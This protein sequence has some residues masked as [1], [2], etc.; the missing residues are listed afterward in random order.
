VEGEL[1]SP[2]TSFHDLVSRLHRGDSS[3]A[4][5]V[6]R[7]FAGRLIGL[8][9]Q[10]LREQ[11]RSKVDPED[12]MQSVLK[13][14]FLRYADGQYELENWDS[15]WSLLTL[16]TLRKCGYK[17]RHFRAARRDVRRE[18]AARPSEEDSGDR[19][20]AIAREPSP[21]EAAVLAETVEHLLHG[22]DERDRGIL[23][24]RLQGETAVRIS[25]QLG[26]SLRTV[27]RVLEHARKRLRRQY[28]S[29]E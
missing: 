8:A 10:R 19:W 4:E 18:V 25:E 16:I 29:E 28:E 22:L 13:S 26:Y 6:F 15:L 1:M 14:F 9:R 24:L 7:R 3:A 23:E 12:V 21:A 5:E 2:Q 27:E 11:V 17:Q 20:Q